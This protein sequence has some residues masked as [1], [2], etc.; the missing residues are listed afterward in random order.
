MDLPIRYTFA[1]GKELVV[2]VLV[3]H[4]ARSRSVNLHRT[5]HYVLDLMEREEGRA[6][7]PV[8]F[9]TDLHPGKI[10]QRLHMDDLGGGEPILTFRHR[11][12]VVAHED[13]KHWRKRSN[14]VSAVLTHRPLVADTAS[15]A[16]LRRMSLSVSG[17]EGPAVLA[18]WLELWFGAT[19]QI[20]RR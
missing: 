1:K 7:V 18:H 11:I 3:E 6:V 20:A 19:H 13:L 16:C 5:A 14:V 10:P 2:V 12:Q 9:V 17:V 15:R 4:W 8:A